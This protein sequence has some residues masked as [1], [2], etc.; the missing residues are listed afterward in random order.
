MLQHPGLG[1]GLG[2]SEISATTLMPCLSP[3]GSLTLDDFTHF[4]PLVKEELRYAIQNRRLSGGMSTAGTSCSGSGSERYPEPLGAKSEV[5]KANVFLLRTEISYKRGSCF[6][7]VF[8]LQFTAEELNRRKRRRER[9]KIAAAKCRNK[10]KEKTD[11]LQKV[12]SWACVRF[13]DRSF[14]VSP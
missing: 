11:G 6:N 8:S 3:P 12:V 10:K 9:N 2:P 5:Q 1:L 4:S 13:I 14:K 7:D